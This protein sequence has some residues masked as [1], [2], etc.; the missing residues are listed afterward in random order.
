M[1][2]GNVYDWAGKARGVYI[3][4]GDFLFPF[5]GNLPG[6]LS[7]FERNYLAKWAPCS[8][9]GIDDIITAIAEVHVE[10]ILTHSFR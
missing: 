6:L 9:L 10:L 7:E 3:S 5:A 2:L 4:E 1:W 8:G